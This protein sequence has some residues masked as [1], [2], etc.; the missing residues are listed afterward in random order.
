VTLLNLHLHMVS[1]FNLIYTF[2]VLLTN[3]IYHRNSRLTSYGR[4]TKFYSGQ[5][6]HNSTAHF[7]AIK[8][9]KCS[10]KVLHFNFLYNDLFKFLFDLPKKTEYLVFNIV[11]I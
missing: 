5:L 8:R 4:Y 2:I 6:I 11:N 3:S 1:R 7:L 9:E 10:A